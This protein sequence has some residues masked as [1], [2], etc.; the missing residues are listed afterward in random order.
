MRDVAIPERGSLR[1]AA[2]HLALA[3]DDNFRARVVRTTGATGASAGGAEPV[4]A[5][6]ERAHKAPLD[7]EAPNVLA[8]GEKGW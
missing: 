3:L 2:R 8:F 6:R 5:E 7:T 4:S 1:A